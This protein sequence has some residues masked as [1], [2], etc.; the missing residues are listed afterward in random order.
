MNSITL[1]FQLG[2][3]GQIINKRFNSSWALMI[4]RDYEHVWAARICGRCLFGNA[5]FTLRV[6]TSWD[7]STVT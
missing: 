7:T 5:D 4:L 6:C 3:P 2:T 1:N